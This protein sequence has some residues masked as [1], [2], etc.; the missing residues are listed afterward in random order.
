M[1]QGLDDEGR[2]LYSNGNSARAFPTEGDI[3]ALQ[4]YYNA[5]LQTKD[6]LDQL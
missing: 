5:L 3:A 1:V 4:D 6:D 2:A